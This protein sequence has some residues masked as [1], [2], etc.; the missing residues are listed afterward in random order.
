MAPVC[1]R[2]EDSGPE[3]KEDRM[4]MLSFSSSSATCCEGQ[5]KLHDCPW[6]PPHLGSLTT[7]GSSPPGHRKHK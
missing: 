3:H 5:S 2:R 6:S 4:L 7:K 1:P